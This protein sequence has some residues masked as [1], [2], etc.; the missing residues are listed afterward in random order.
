[1][2]NIIAENVKKNYV[3]KK[4]KN[5]KEIW[6]KIKS[7]IVK[8][9]CFEIESMIFNQTEYKEN[10]DIGNGFNKY[11]VDS[12]ISIRDSISYVQY[13]NNIPVINFHFIHS[14]TITKKKM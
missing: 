1:M 3:N 12:V 9:N 14:L 6:S 13:G 5:D 10:S 4:M 7:H 11:F 2:Y 8:K